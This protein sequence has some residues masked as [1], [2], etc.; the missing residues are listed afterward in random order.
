[1]KVETIRFV[2]RNDE[3]AYFIRAVHQLATGCV[4]LGAR[5]HALTALVDVVSRAVGERQRQE[6]KST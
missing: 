2:A 6:G 1:M 5:E 4:V 3:E